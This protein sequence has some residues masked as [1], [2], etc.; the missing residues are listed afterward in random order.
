MPILA[1]VLVCASVSLAALVALDLA[2]K[3][4]ILNGIVL[5]IYLPLALNAVVLA[6]LMYNSLGRAW[7]WPLIGLSLLFGYVWLRL[8]LFP[9]MDGVPVGFR[10]KAL[11]GATPILFSLVYATIV[12]AIVIPIGFVRYGA[13]FPR[14]VLV[15]NAIYSLGCCLVL[16]LNGS[17]RAIFAAKSLTLLT[18]VLLVC[19]LWIPVIGWML[20]ASVARRVRREYH[21]AVDRVEWER[22]QPH[23]D[24]CST[25]YPILLVHGVG[26]RDRVLFNAWGRIPQYLKRH[27]ADLFYGEQE[28][29]GTIEQNGQQVADRIKEVLDLTGAAKVNI[30]AH[31]KGGLDSRY[32]ITALELGEKVASLTTMNTPHRGVRFADTATKMKEPLY[33]KLAAVVNFIFAKAGDEAPDF[34]TATMGFRTEQ[35]EEFNRKTPD[36]PGV[37]YQSYTSVMSCA[38]SDRLLA[39]PYR[40]IKALGED[41]DGLV[42]VESAKWGEFRGVLTSTSRRGIAHG[43]LVD[44]NR[45]DYAGFNVLDAYITIVEDLKERGF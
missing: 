44:V 32:A 35:S 30:I 45:E 29:W 40:I 37:Y 1:T 18:R 42:S 11:G 39:V 26:W 17:I 2:R 28:A 20:A 36:H 41:N 27:G 19:A 5:A 38:A 3:I 13:E 31:S 16:Y 6:Y 22:A 9:V 34:V 8:N 4:P 15:T 21:A 12:Q 24:R 25:R 33:N 14:S 7:L 23:S 10:L 43:D